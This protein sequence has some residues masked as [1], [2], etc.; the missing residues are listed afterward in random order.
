[1]ATAEIGPR[2]VIRRAREEDAGALR[3]IFNEAIQD[4]LA[5][6]DTEPT[7]LE[8]QQRLIAAATQDCRHPILVAELRNWALGWITVQPYD[9]RPQLADIGEVMVY[10]RRSFRSYGVGRQLMQTVQQEARS[11][12]YRKLIGRVLAD[13]YGSLRLC[14]TTGWREVGRHE[15]HARH[16]ERQRDVVI[17]E[18]HVPQPAGTS[19]IPSDSSTG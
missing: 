14:R 17:V 3:E 2:L 12:G 9:L 19:A 4:G 10:V 16:G 1:M 6:F 18:Y 8:E 13:H 15:Q 7:S 5:T 11:L